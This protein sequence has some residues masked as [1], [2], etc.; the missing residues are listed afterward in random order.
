MHPRCYRLLV[1]RIYQKIKSIRKVSLLLCIPKS[2]IHRWVTETPSQAYTRRKSKLDHPFVIDVIK[3]FLD[4]HP[5]SSIYEVQKHISESVDINVSYELLRLF[6][7]NKLS[8]SFKKPHFYPSQDR[9]IEKTRGFCSDYRLLS[10][11][12]VCPCIVSIDEVGFS[13]NVRPLKGWSVKGVPF[14]VRYIPSSKEKRR[15]SCCVAIT[16][17]G[18]L[19]FS[20]LEGHFTKVKFLD[21]LKI[22]NFP[23]KSLL[24]MDNV[25]F[26]HSKDVLDYCLER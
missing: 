26:H 18:K 4:R 12:K 9:L 7:R 22:Q 13:S 6:I 24:L 11:S 21:F 15:I 8:Y 19:S 16:N 23:A 2:T 17:K 10:D 5:F 14:H 1:R 20:S 3:A 25:S